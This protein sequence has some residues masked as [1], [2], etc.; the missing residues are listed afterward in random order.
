[1]P[2]SSLAAFGSPR[3]LAPKEP[4]PSAAPTYRPLLAGSSAAWAAAAQ[5]HKAERVKK[6]W[7]ERFTIN[8][9][10]GSKRLA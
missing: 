7:M 5:R 4:R 10:S 6:F 8:T 9:F 1:M 2:V 3:S